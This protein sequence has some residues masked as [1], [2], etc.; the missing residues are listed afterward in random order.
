MVIVNFLKNT[1]VLI[2]ELLTLVIAILWYFEKYD[3]E[4][5]IAVIGISLSIVT[6]IS[7]K[8]QNHKSSKHDKAN[9]ETIS[10]DRINES[11]NTKQTKIEIENDIS[12]YKHLPKFGFTATSFFYQRMCDAFPG[13]RGLS[14]IDDPKVANKRLEIL[15]KQPLHFRSRDDNDA[16]TSPIWWFRGYSSNSIEFYKRIS[17][18]KCLINYKEIEIDKLYIYRSSAYY[19][20]FVYILTKPE[21][22]TGIENFSNEI[23]KRHVEESGYSFEEYGLLNNKYPISRKEYDDGNAVIKGKIIDASEAELRMRFITPYNFIITSQ[24][25]PINESDYDQLFETILNNIIN[26]SDNIENLVSAIKILKRNNLDGE[27]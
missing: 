21:K 10:S 11:N 8:F 23:I 19:Q 5:L 9:L 16:T 1:Y 12:P 26:G 13:M 2:V 24:F 22:Q 4:P 20:E 14:C 18:T 6:N 3:K 17:K 25:S 7:L 27:L 15:L